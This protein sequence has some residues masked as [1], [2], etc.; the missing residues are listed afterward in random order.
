MS[1]KCPELDLDDYDYELPP[2]RIAQTPAARRDSSRLLVLD[3]EESRGKPTHSQMHALA[4]FLEP[5]DLLVVNATRVVPARLRGKRESGGAVE[6]LLLGTLEASG[7]DTNRYRALIKQSGR[8]RAGIRIRFE[9]VDPRVSPIAAEIV[10]LGPRGEVT[11]EF[12]AGAAPYSV[13]ETPLPPYIERKAAE[14]ADRQR[15]QT[16]FAREPGAVAAPTA[17]LHFTPELL[18]TLESRG[19]ETSEVILHVGPGTFRP[20]DDENLRSGRLHS[21]RF[22]LPQTTVDAIARTR[23]RGGRVVAVGT[24][25]TRVLEAN[26]PALQPGTGETDL[27]LRPGARFRVVDALL[28][29]FHLPRSSLL[30]L[31]AAFAG[32]ERILAAYREAIENEYRFYSYGDAMLIL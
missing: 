26:A 17:G 24:T 7:K 2:D 1:A 18:G 29:N 8:L 4:D 12:P 23:A 22:E 30:L 19:I 32:R 9:S 28:T 25:S 6:A 14:D 16:I 27:F 31:V 21:E 13:G 11:L 10:A 15:Y 5:G 20:L 3:R